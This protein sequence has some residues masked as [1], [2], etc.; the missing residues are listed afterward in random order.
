[1]LCNG[2]HLGVLYDLEEAQP[3]GGCVMVLVDGIQHAE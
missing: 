3:L 2:V 1:M